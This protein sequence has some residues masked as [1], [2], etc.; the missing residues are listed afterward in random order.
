MMSEALRRNLITVARRFGARALPV[1]F[2]ALLPLLAFAADDHDSVIG[3]PNATIWKTVNFFVLVG[4]IAYALRGKVGPFFKERNKAIAAGISD[5]ASR[6]EEARK[7][8][9]MVEAK[10]AGLEADIAALRENAKGEMDR[11]RRRVEAETQTAVTRIREQAQREIVSAGMLARGQLR[12]HAARLAM[13]LAE[14]QVSARAAEP[15]VRD[16]L[17]DAALGRLA[18]H[19]KN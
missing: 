7:R 9:E 15:G 10:L 5:A 3:G 16:G 4:I 14:Q 19:S 8:M 2:T 1:A 17:L 13:E 12:Q 18:Q 11:D 6:E